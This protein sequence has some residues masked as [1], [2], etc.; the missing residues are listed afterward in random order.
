MTSRRRI[1]TWVLGALG[2]V[3]GLALLLALVGMLLPR[4][5][6]A[7][8]AIELAAAPERVWAIVSDFAG[9]AR[10]RPDLE[11][12]RLESP[13]GGRLR[14]VETTGE[15]DTP[16]EV[17][18]Q[19]PPRR[20]VVRVV[21][22]GLPFGGTWTW[23]LVPLS[24][25]TGLTLTEEGFVRNPVYRAMGLLFFRPTEGITRYLGALATAL[26]EDAEP[27]VWQGGAAPR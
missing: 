4:E 11:S 24:G 8:A 25:G 23:E 1:R 19:D 16:F 7:R 18:S 12:V 9:A 20:Q 3:I 14:F 6:T 2:A 26:G 5:H 22:D 15:G 17:V 21:D 13:A 27:V 10:W